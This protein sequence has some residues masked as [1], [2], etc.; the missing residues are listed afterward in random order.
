M[1][2]LLARSFVGFPALSNAFKTPEAQL[3]VIVKVGQRV[4]W[5]EEVTAKNLGTSARL[6]RT[7]G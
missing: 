1:T 7:C 2:F 3:T 4:R 5:T 6:S